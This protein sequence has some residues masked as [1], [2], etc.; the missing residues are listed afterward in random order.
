ML[1]KSSA[2]DADNFLS[3]L[4]GYEERVMIAKR[5]ACLILILEGISPYKASLILKI[6]PSTA[7]K[8][9]KS[10]EAKNYDGIIK[11]LAKNTKNYRSILDTIDSILHLNGI[12]PH[13]NGLDRY[14][15]LPKT[16]NRLEVL[17]RV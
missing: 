10:I 9:Q 8:V 15:N 13:Y 1:G 4:L 2:S 12:L 3:E 5:L 16:S 17:L 6:S 7:D 14:K 11:L